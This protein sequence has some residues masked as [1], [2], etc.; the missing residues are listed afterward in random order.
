MKHE[1]IIRDLNDLA[2]GDALTAVRNLGAFNLFMKDLEKDVEADPEHT[3]FAVCFFDC[4]DLKIINDRYGHDKG[5][6]YLKGACATICQVFSHSPVF[7]I[8]GDEFAAILRNREYER[9]EELLEQVNENE[10]TEL[11]STLLLNVYPYLSFAT[12]YEALPFI[13]FHFSEVGVTKGK[14]DNSDSISNADANYI[15]AHIRSQVEVM[16]KLLKKFLD[17]HHD[18]YPLYPFDGSNCDCDCE[19][20]DDNLWILQYYG[21]MDKYNWEKFRNMCR[22]KRDKPNPHIQVYATP[23]RNNDIV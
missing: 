16:K 19:C 7:R 14:S 17:E 20:D 18:L 9:R 5:D 13:Q 10:V 6:I 22:I 3:H 12:C 1:I 23:R 4:N 15:N 8:G 11:N 2:Y 21:G